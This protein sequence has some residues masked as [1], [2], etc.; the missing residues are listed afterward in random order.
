MAT[1]ISGIGG[2]SFA[3]VRRLRACAHDR[4]SLL[5]VKS[6]AKELGFEAEG[7]QLSVQEL[8]ERVKRDGACAVLHV[9]GRHFVLAVTRNGMLLIADPQRRVIPVKH[10][11]LSPH[12]SWNGAA[13]VLNQRA[14]LQN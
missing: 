13:V 8:R 11:T 10:G 4:L 3:E 9:D 7:L 6:A 5:D 2:V 12:Y 1:R 14:K